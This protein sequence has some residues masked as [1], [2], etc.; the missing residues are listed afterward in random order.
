MPYVNF[1][2]Q[3]DEMT[4]VYNASQYHETDIGLAMV[5]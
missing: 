4:V 1:D 2:M 5:C 3:N